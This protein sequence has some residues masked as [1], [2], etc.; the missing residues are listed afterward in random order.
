MK[1]QYLQIETYILSLPTE[2]YKFAQD[3]FFEAGMWTQLGLY[4]DLLSH[5][6]TFF[7]VIVCSAQWPMVLV[8]TCHGR[9]R[10]YQISVLYKLHQ[11]TYWLT[12]MLPWC[13]DTGTT[14]LVGLLSLLCVWS[15]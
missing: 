7:T 14:Q 2:L 13:R 12:S 4:I 5:L 11:D 3:K 8:Y 9:E 6:F 1:V 10:V 15:F